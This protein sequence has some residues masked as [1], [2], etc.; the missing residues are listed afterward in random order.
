MKSFEYADE[1]IDYNQ[2]RILIPSVLIGAGILSLPRI[3]AETTNYAD[4]W[5]SILAGG[6]LAVTFTWVVATLASRFPKQSFFG[7]SSLLLSKPVAYIITIFIALYFLVFTAYEIRSVATLSKEY[8]F[9]ATP[10]EVLSLVFLLVVIYAVSGSRVALFRLNQLFLPIIIGALV[11]ILLISIPLLKTEN[12]VP[13]FK[14]SWSGHLQGIKSTFLSFMGWGI[15]L[16]YISL[17]NQ[18]KRASKAAVSGIFVPIII[19]LL[20]YITSIGV[21]SNI[22][23]SNITYPTNELAKVIEVPGGFLESLEIVFFTVWVM[24]LFTT[25]M[26]FFDITVMALNSL[27]KKTKKK[28]LILILAPIIYLVSMLPQDNLDINKLSDAL[29]YTGLIVSVV[30]PTTLLLL[31]KFKGVKGNG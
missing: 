16:F 17:M 23:T 8:L 26:I 21:F 9:D 30:I 5:I 31:A 29:G 3:L 28:T 12:L 24:A 10:I 20:I 4:G 11:V 22:M 7:Y 13:L 25:T 18:P 2:I 1:E 27:L 6:F 14:T 19:Y 15:L